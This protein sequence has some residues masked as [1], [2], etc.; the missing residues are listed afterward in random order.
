MRA[1]A[2]AAIAALALGGCATTSGDPPPPAARAAEQPAGDVPPAARQPASEATPDAP[3][4]DPGVPA[5]AARG[6]EPLDPV[7][8][9]IGAPVPDVA[10]VDLAG[11]AH[12]LHD[13]AAPGGLVVVCTALACP[14]TKA[15]TPLLNEVAAAAER[16]GYAF[17]ALAPEALDD[18]DALRAKAQR[19]GWRFSVT[20]DP[21]FSLC[22]AL[23]VRR[24]ADCFLLDRTGVLR[25]RGAIDDRIGFGYVRAT[26]R[27]RLLLDAIE[28]LAAGRDV[29]QPATEAPG[30]V[31]SRVE[32]PR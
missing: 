4:S 25:Y 6:P 12:T 13:L 30:C 8:A 16:A 7:E 5:Y 3:P 9:G 22:D 11:E 14:V 15:Y 2:L 23:G 27:A 29:A 24:T 32:L 20:R 26:P 1:R 31:V 28:A 21:G 17:L 19:V 18:A 10:F